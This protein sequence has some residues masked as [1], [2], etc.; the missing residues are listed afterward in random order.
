MKS[1]AY[2]KSQPKKLSDKDLYHTFIAKFGSIQVQEQLNNLKD[3]RELAKAGEEGAGLKYL[4]RIQDK[5]NEKAEIII[6]ED[7]LSDFEKVHR[8]SLKKAQTLFG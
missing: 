6:R 7:P 4:Q 2:G 8:Q 5:A 3:K 1:I